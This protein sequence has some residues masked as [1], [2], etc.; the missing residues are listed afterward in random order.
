VTAF[1]SSFDSGI[2][3]PPFTFSHTFLLAGSFPYF[4]LV[5]S[6]MTATV[7]VSGTSTISFFPQRDN[8]LYE[9]PTGQLSN[10]QG[11]YFYDGKTGGNL[12][13]RGLIAFD[14]TSIPANAIVTNASLSMF[15][16]MAQGGPQ[17]VTVSKVSQDWGEG[18]SDAGDPGG[19]GAPA[20]AG[21]AT[22][23]HTFYNL[24]FWTA[25]GGDFSPDASASTMVDAVDTTYTWSGSGLVADVQ[26]WVSNPTG[27]F[28]WVVRGNEVDS[29]RAQRFNSGENSSNQ[30]QLSVTYQFSAPTPTPTPTSTPTPPVT[31]TPPATPTPTATPSPTPSPTPT[32]TPTATP[33]TLGNISTRL[34][35]LTDNNVLI[36]GLIATGTGNTRVI[37]R[38]IGPSLSD[39]GVPGAMANPTLDLFQGS[40]LLMSNDDWQNS[41]Q[42]A[43]IAASGFAPGNDLESAIIW[44]LAPG[45][46]YT[47]IVRGING[48]TGVG[49]VEAY[50]L[51]HSPSSRLANIS[52]RGFVDVDNNVMIAG[53]IV[54]P[55][56]GTSAR[57]LARALGPSLADLGVP[58]ALV[59]T[60]LDLVNSSGTVVRSNN[61]WKDDP[62]QRSAI[63]AAGLAPAHDEE[64]AL[65]ETV[66][67]GAYTA[68]VRGSNRTTG[69]GLVEVYHIP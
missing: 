27:N 60:T 66:A 24:G 15:L 69:V 44:P 38:A 39:L 17:E 23:L 37:L 13:R 33:G 20:A 47:A 61:N 14:L 53:L 25:L 41:S 55:G 30:P 64:A 22:W 36:G 35:V 59:D 19:G 28:G 26:A 43:E 46:G 67:P 52:T 40:T 1:D 5:H 6:M 56:N 45:Q 68:I 3:D 2:H 49:V 62:L 16:S 7:E 51:D 63:E 57:I 65:V 29:G 21:D 48:T 10:G 11:I 31:P 54:G 4:C 42:Q 9:D 58:G 12:L 50:D 34:R 8:T 32:A 18:A